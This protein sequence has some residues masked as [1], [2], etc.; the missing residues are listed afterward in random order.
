MLRIIKV[1][2]R[3]ETRVETG[4]LYVYAM[5]DFSLEAAKS[6][7]IEMLE[8]I[9]TQKVE[10]IIFDGR[11]LTGEPKTIERFY[12]GEFAAQA[13]VE[14]EDRGVSPATQ[15]AYIL[16]EPVLDPLRFGET[17]AVNRGMFVKAFDNLQD[18][19][20]WLGISPSIKTEVA[21]TK[22]FN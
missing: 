10:K 16:E 4:F 19:L 2:M 21:M 17:V 18:A 22:R 1:D 8:I 11:K 5:G 15:F 14:F 13:V 6:S 20:R 3:I 7:F 12:Y 9:A